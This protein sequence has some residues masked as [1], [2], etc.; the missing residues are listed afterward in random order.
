MTSILFVCV[1]NGGKS[2]M[3][4]ALAEKYAAGSLDIHS[5]G[6]KPGTKLNSESVE[7]ISEVGADMSQGTPKP[8]DPELLSTVDRVVILGEDAQLNMPDD[9]QGAL[10]RWVTDEPSQRGIEGM[11]RMRLV[12]D[13]IDARVRGLL[14]ELGVGAE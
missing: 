13:D 5:A 12:R 8:I 6:T 14:T 4:A 3:A 7:A 2:Q 1:G 9:A 10:E 11:E